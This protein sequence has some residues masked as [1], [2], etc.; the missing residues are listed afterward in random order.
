MKFKVGFSLV[1]LI[2]LFSVSS[3]CASEN[4]TCDTSNPVLAGNDDICE[5]PDEP[6]LN[7]S[8]ES[9]VS[10]ASYQDDIELNVSLKS[11][12]GDSHNVNV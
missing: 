1:I 3:V 4:L 12:G 8:V 5:S 9:N 6:A 2:V 11:V 10:K 7:L